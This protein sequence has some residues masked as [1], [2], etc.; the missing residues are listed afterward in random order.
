MS[1]ECR[2]CDNCSKNVLFESFSH[3]KSHICEIYLQYILCLQHFQ[4]AVKAWNLEL[5]FFVH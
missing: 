4:L 1:T 2:K 5:I 3:I